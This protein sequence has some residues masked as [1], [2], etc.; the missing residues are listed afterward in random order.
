MTT[1]YNFDEVIDRRNTQSAKWSNPDLLPLW[2]ADMDFESP[3]AVGEAIRKRAAHNLYGYDRLP[4]NY[5]DT[6]QGWF[7]RR[8][9][10]KVEREWLVT[11][12]GVVEALFLIINALTLPGDAV[13]IQ[14]PVY[15]PFEYSV[16][17]SGRQL[18]TSPMRR[19]GRGYELDLEDLEAKLAQSL[20]KLLILCNPHNPIGKVYTREELTAIGELALR[21]RVVVVSDEIHGDLIM[22]GHRH[23]P[24]A[25]ICEQFAQNSVTCTAPSKTFNLA[26]LATS[27]I[28]IPDP[29]LRDRFT[30][31]SQCLGIKGGNLYGI[32]ACEAAYREG[33]QWLD[34]LLCYIAG[35]AGFFKRYL[36]ENIPG[37]SA[38]DLQGTYLQWVDFR[39]L[40]LSK[41][42]LEALLHDK[43]RLW[44]SQGYIFGEEGSGFARFNLATQRSTLTRA[45]DQLEEAVRT[46]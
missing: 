25:S 38:D 21:H 35:N 6:L 37:V 17:R 24:F 26:G 5:F 7:S 11:T 43:A 13:L 8:Q 14:P 19:T 27:N 2:V 29:D 34:E 32:I 4:E 28:F 39:K 18:V 10:F 22:E 3:P 30:R 20:V 15:H 9:G 23:I 16:R 45:L 12:S 41:E 40:G 46:L 31:F 36:E 33:E 44:L 1:E 42:E